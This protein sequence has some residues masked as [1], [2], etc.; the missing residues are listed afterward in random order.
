MSAERDILSAVMAH[1]LLTCKP[2]RV[3]VIAKELGT[4]T[5]T[6]NRLA[7]A[8]R[9]L[10]FTDVEHEVVNKNYGN[11]VDGKWIMSPALQPTR[12]HLVHLIIEGTT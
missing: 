4:N 6:V 2:V 9:E 10:Q 5:A 1:Y 11:L 8:C 7:N 3:S 12:E